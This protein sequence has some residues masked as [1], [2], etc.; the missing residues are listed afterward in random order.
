MELSALPKTGMAGKHFNSL[1]F[2]RFAITPFAQLRKPG[3][4]I[5]RDFNADLLQKL[6]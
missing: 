4:G 3:W 6:R 2:S 5:T 1:T